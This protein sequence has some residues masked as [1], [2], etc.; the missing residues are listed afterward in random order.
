MAL[1]KR[2]E[3]LERA[4]ADQ[5]LDD[6]E[7]AFDWMVQALQAKQATKQADVDAWREAAWANLQARELR[8]HHSRASFDECF[9]VWL[10]AEGGE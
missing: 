3:K 5:V 1:T 4:V 10:E 8:H 6:G 7:L 2:V 9:A